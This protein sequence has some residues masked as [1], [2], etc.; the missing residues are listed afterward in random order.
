MT[1]FERE[2]NGSLGAYWKAE[3]EKELERVKADLDA[4]KITIDEMLA[5]SQANLEKYLPFLMQGLGISEQDIQ[6]PANAP[7]GY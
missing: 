2:L 4:G 7:V 1:R 3:A 5:R 6:N